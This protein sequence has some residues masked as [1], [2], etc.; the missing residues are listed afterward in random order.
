MMMK[1]YEESVAINHKPNWSYIS[2]HHYKILTIGGSGLGKTNVLLNWI[3][4]QR[5]N[6]YKIYLHVR[7]PF[8]SKYQLLIN[9]REE[10]GIKELNN[11]K[12]F[13][14][15]S[16]TLDDIYKISKAVIHTKKTNFDSVW[17]YL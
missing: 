10:V 7:D 8:E 1:Y 16:Q 14:D 12:A 11:P 15:Y 9:R 5:P 3:K 13:I 6:I 2:D 4:H 17:W